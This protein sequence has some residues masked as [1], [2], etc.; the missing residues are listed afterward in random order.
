M[1]Y[2]Q[3]KH[4]KISGLR[5]HLGMNRPSPSLDLGSKTH[6]QG[7]EMLAQKMGAP[8]TPPSPVRSN[9]TPQS[10]KA[11]NAS[12]ELSRPLD[13]FSMAS[14]RTPMSSPNQ[15]Q[16]YKRGKDGVTSFEGSNLN[17]AMNMMQTQSLAEKQIYTPENNRQFNMMKSH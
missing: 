6:G 4:N 17:E 5:Q 7:K 2:N 16:G 12:R 13:M 11:G 10:R 1:L 9:P 3:I 15:P 14:K 8:P